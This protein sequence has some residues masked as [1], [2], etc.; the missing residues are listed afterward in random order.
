MR[1]HRP[2]SVAILVAALV[3]PIAA[4]GNGV[5]ASSN[6][7]YSGV[8]YLAG[9][10]QVVV[11]S[12]QPLP[13]ALLADTT[14]YVPI[15]PRPSQVTSRLRVR[16]SEAGYT[17][18]SLD[19]TG[20]VIVP[21]GISD[22][23]D[24]TVGFGAVVRRL[25]SSRMEGPREG[26][27][28]FAVSDSTRVYLFFSPVVSIPPKSGQAALQGAAINTSGSETFT[29]RDGGPRGAVFTTCVVDED[30]SGSRTG[31]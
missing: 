10:R 11:C 15:S 26:G 30:L 23:V 16:Q 21:V 6:I 31:S 24:S 8:Y 2:S 14:R 25:V 17:I 3:M 29:F 12:P 20:H 1:L 7:D 4:C 5:T 9:T 13:A 19:S 27:H 22:M 28:T 18:V